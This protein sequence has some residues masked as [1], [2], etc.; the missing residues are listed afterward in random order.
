MSL[1]K[2]SKATGWRISLCP[3]D[4]NFSLG[5]GHDDVVMSATKPHSFCQAHSS[6]P[7]RPDEGTLNPKVYLLFVIVSS[8]LFRRT[9][10]TRVA[11]ALDLQLEAFHAFMKD[12]TLSIP[13]QK[14]PP[15]FQRLEAERS[16]APPP[17]KHPQLKAVARKR[18][19]QAS[20]TLRQ[21][22]YWWKQEVKQ[23]GWHWM[24]DL[25]IRMIQ[26]IQSWPF[27]FLLLLDSRNN[28]GSSA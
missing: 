11:C 20:H 26:C 22:R 2:Q 8:R 13:L 12:T 9:I 7:T 3:Q 6:R 23:T 24:Y 5:L 16:G 25:M 28:P 15:L 18:Y 27:C 4:C 1:W 19:F 17:R 14:R 21:G 10:W